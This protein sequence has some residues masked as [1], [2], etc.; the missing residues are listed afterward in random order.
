MCSSD[1]VRAMLNE[2]GEPVEFAGPSRPVQVLGFTSVPSAGDSFL[3]ADEDRTARQ[4]A[5]KRLAAERH[6]ALAKARK[7]VSLEDFM[8]QSKINTLNLIIKGDVS[9]SVEALEDALMAIE[10][11]AEVDLR[12][13]HRGV[14]AI[15]KSDI[16]LASAS[17]R[18][19]T[20]LNSSH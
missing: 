2:D 7:K 6:A 3:V 9:G 16:D 19:S 18:K 11:G 1:L 5:E 8:E 15:T 10:V 13:I 17:D 14:G 20:R 12:V 4:I